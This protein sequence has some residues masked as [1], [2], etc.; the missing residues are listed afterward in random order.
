[1]EGPLWNLSA[2][3]PNRNIGNQKI[4]QQGGALTARHR[5]TRSTGSAAA[6]PDEGSRPATAPPDGAPPLATAP[7][8]GAPPL[9]AAPPDGA[10]PP[11]ERKDSAFPTIRLTCF[12]APPPLR[13]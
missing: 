5:L 1:M 4:R 13:W 8:D 10:A 6:P 2:H 11:D 7:P 9:A 12:E 3:R